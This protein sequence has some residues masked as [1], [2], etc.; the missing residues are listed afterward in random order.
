MCRVHGDRVDRR[1]PSGEAAR[2]ADDAWCSGDFIPGTAPPG[3]VVPMAVA[4]DRGLR[5]GMA[6]AV[7]ASEMNGVAAPR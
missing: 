6:G 2:D 4:L 1:E 5:G 3:T 7:E